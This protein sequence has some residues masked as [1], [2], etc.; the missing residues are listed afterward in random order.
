MILVAQVRIL[1]GNS[2]RSRVGFRSGI[3]AY[4]YM[5]L[6][7]QVTRFG[8][9]IS[10]LLFRAT[11]GC[12]RRSSSSQLIWLIGCSG[13]VLAALMNIAI[14]SRCLR[15]LDRSLGNLTQHVSVHNVHLSTPSAGGFYAEYCRDIIPMRILKVA[16]MIEKSPSGLS[17]SISVTWCS[18]AF[19]LG[20]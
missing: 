15:Y 16:L 12:R 9:F 8:M 19:G 3:G 4:V 2:I 5:R 10:R 7:T 14:A 13:Q 18:L 11:V 1:A 20:S 17:R 6:S